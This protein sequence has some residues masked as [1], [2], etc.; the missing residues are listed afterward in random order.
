MKELTTIVL[1]EVW[2]CSAVGYQEASRITKANVVV[3]TW[4]SR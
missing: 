1:R 4:G 2:S 3:A